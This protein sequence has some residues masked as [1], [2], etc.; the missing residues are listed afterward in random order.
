[1]QSK[2]ASSQV[3]SICMIRGAARMLMV[4]LIMTALL[5]LTMIG[6]GFLL[7]K[8]PPKEINSVIGYRSS[9]SAKNRDTWAFAHGYSGKMWIRSGIITAI[10]S[11]AFALALQSLSCYK[12][13]MVALIYIQ[14]AIL[15]SVIPATE[16]A[17]RKTFDKNGI[18]KQI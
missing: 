12:Q 13:L 17:L 15:L 1:M 14:I 11:V 2:T 18:R 3:N 10:L 16:I 7:A 6:F 8:K 5:S 9:M 4:S